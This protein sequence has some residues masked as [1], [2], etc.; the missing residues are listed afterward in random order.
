MSALKRPKA[1]ARKTSMHE[2]QPIYTQTD[3]LHA[4]YIIDKPQRS[5]SSF[6]EPNHFLK[7]YPHENVV[8]THP[9]NEKT[10]KYLSCSILEI[11][12]NNFLNKRPVSHLPCVWN[13]RKFELS[14]LCHN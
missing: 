1:T 3:M 11:E 6:N 9:V 2:A 8:S 4:K 10:L 12:E 13:I 14:S 5:W 7:K